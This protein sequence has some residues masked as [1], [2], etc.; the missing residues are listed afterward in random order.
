MSD[1]CMIHLLQLSAHAAISMGT[2]TWLAC[3]IWLTTFPYYCIAGAKGAAAA[4]EVDPTAVAVYG[5]DALASMPEGRQGGGDSGR[6][7]EN[8]DNSSVASSM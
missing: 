5:D 4:A 6:K 8:D 1:V 7:A 3:N 2:A